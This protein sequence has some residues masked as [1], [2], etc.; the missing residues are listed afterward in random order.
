[1][2]RKL[3]QGASIWT[4][5]NALVEHIIKPAKIEVAQLKNGLLPRRGP[6]KTTVRIAFAIE[7]AEERLTNGTF[8][9]MQFLSA[10]SH[11]YAKM[12]MTEIE[13]ARYLIHL[14]E[15]AGV[16]AQAELN[17]LKSDRLT[18]ALD[19]AIRME[20]VC[21]VISKSFLRVIVISFL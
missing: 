5:L 7:C 13:R 20:A 15:I 16:E 11:L 4:F 12:K 2:K 6:K 18:L 14:E 21:K 1:M 19:E 10:V 8:T 9:T 17:R 3:P